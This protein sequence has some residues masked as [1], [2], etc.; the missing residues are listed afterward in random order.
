MLVKQCRNQRELRQQIVL[1]KLF[2]DYF[3]FFVQRHHLMIIDD[4]D[5]IQ[6]A[7]FVIH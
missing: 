1:K 6:H 4:V 2:A 7:F 5:I 3:E